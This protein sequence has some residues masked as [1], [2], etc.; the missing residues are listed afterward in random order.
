[1]SAGINSMDISGAADTT[2]VISGRNGRELCSTKHHNRDVPSSRPPPL[3]QENLHKKGT[4]KLD[5]EEKG[6][7]TWYF[8]KDDKGVLYNDKQKDK[9]E[10]ER[11][12][13]VGTKKQGNL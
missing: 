13:K 11:M 5:K 10:H 9:K 3:Y 6:E 8:R 4:C 2:A 12:G 7:M 1:M